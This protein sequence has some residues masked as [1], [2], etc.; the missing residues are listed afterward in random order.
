MK[1][2]THLTAIGCIVFA[3]SSFVAADSPSRPE[4][5]ITP[6]LT[7]PSAYA[8][9]VDGVERPMDTQ[10]REQTPQW[11]LWTDARN[12]QPGHSGMTFGNSKSPG[13]RHLR[14][15]FRQVIPVGSVVVRG[16][17]TLSV[18]RA[19]AAYPGDLNDDSQWIPAGRLVDAEPTRN[20][21][22]ESRVGKALRQGVGLWTLPPGVKTRAIRFTHV[23]Q[24]ADESY[25]GRLGGVMVLTQR[26][27][28]LAPLATP[29][30][31]SNQKHVA[32]IINGAKDQW[33]EWE[34][35]DGKTATESGRPVI[36]ESNPEWLMLT[37]PRAVRIDRLITLWTGFGAAEVLV[38]AGPESRHPREA[39]D[40][41]WRSVGIYR[42]LQNG[43]PAQLWPNA[44]LFPEPVETRAIRLR[45]IEPSVGRHP[46]TVERP[47]G[48]KRVWLGELFACHN[49]GDAPLKTGVVDF[50]RNL[51]ARNS[52][53]FHYG[54]Q[55]VA[56]APVPVRFHL[57]DD[58]FVTLVIEDETGKRVRNL[59]SE[60]PF[61]AGDNVVWWDAT[62]DL[63]RDIE[64]A[65]HGLYNIPARL[66]SPGRYSARGLWRKEIEPFYEFA[67]YGT[68]NPP[69][70]TPDH[71]GAW[72]AN[73]SPPSAAVFVPARTSP[74]G[75]PAVFLGCYVT[76]GPDG[77]AWVDLDGTKRGG[78]KWIG[79]H[80]TA[81]PYLGRDTGPEAPADV[82]AYVASTWET[83]KKSSI[84]ELRVTALLRSGSGL[85][86]EPVVAHRL[87]QSEAGR[88]QFEQLG[89]IA[90]YN[91]V[92]VCSFRQDDHLLWI[93]A[94]AGKVLGTTNVPSPRGVCFDAQ[95][96]LLV[97]SG[98]KLL[99]FAEARR[100]E[101]LS[102]PETVISE[103]LDDPFGLTVA[104]G[105]GVEGISFNGKPKATV[106]ASAANTDA[107]G[108]PL[109]E[110]STETIYIS[111]HGQRH[112]VKLFDAD[113]KPIRTIG[114]P[115]KPRAGDYDKLHMN[116]PAGIAVDS[117]GQ[118]W[119]T[120]HDYLPKRVS[121]WSQEGE[122]VNAFYG[123]SKYGGGGALDS[124][125]PSLFY[126]ADEA[127]GSLEFALDWE[128]GTS[129]LKRVL[130]RARTDFPMP[131]R[132]AAPERSLYHNGQRYFTNCYNTNPVAGH[133]TA[134]LFQDRDGVA[135]PAAAMGMAN[136]WD[137]LKTEPFL[138]LWPEGPDPHSKDIHGHGGR[139]QVFFAWSDL[140]TDARVQPEEVWMEQAVCGGVTVM[141]D[142]SFC[143]ARL[144]DQ[145]VR[146]TPTSF[147]TAGIPV[148]GRS[149]RVVLA[150]GVQRPGSSGGDQVL[151]DASNEAVITLGVEPFHR[152]SL[153][154]TR[155][156][157]PVWSYPSP[158]PGL[159][160]SHEA[161]SPSFPG[162]VIGSTRLMG[163]LF[164]VKG[165]EAGPLWAVNANM[166][167]FY[168][169]TRDGLFVATVF[170]D[171]RQ[172]KL[173]KMP[174]ATRG[175]PLQGISL[176]DENFWPTITSTP[177]GKVY[178]VDGSYSSLVRLEGLDTIR[179]LD[180]FSVEVTAEHLVEA[181]RWVLAR[182]AQ[183][184]AEFGQGVLNASI[185]PTS[186]IKTDGQSDD[187]SNANWVDIEKRGVR[188]NF[189]SNSQPFNVSGSLAI[190][191]DRLHAAWRTTLN[192][193]LRNS[194]EIPH[195]LF[196]TGGGLDLMLATNPAA[197]PKRRSP[198]AGDLRLLITQVDG[199]PRAL[200]YE[201]VSPGSTGEKVPFSSPW[202]TTTFDRVEDVSDQIELATDGK[203]FYE[204][205]ISLKTLGLKATDG[206]RMKGDIGILRGTGTETTARSY[207]SN[208][209]TGIT[210]DVP[211]E[212]ALT[213]HLWGTIQWKTS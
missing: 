184:Q 119:V 152:H 20:P 124:A 162:Q 151:A 65:R 136:A 4:T 42:G 68:G 208:K 94:A 35:V 62:D 108:L 211:S 71:T 90:A 138:F 133:S 193:L 180:A 8:E 212:A 157:K 18:L 101:K 178:A 63:G 40:G 127:R 175:M 61:P 199:K 188:A 13:A 11:V 45:M 117:K 54:V 198:V 44:M 145:A 10:R 110:D 26:L 47:A 57:P 28:N 115:G 153:S 183:R 139:N 189:N 21:I 163:G 73:H 144:N 84:T 111:D 12:G 128:K 174:V 46:H 58:G 5:P 52:G 172:G 206:L 190:S 197:D 113:G 185:H 176:H 75:E 24:P 130:Y 213:P 112:Q 36:S 51:N 135:Q 123:P 205:S 132:A 25:A 91:G 129:E 22:L 72:L 56:H 60:T 150:D 14:I 96:R 186:R 78:L 77:F 81:A 38:Y 141:E 168:L 114:R 100:P 34:N 165:C 43:Y 87:E 182:E 88:H 161:A 203:G 37:W 59:V 76:E 147:T 83:D 9:W 104:S 7:N 156:G 137:V 187:W 118:I 103:G 64:A 210:A 69:W 122:L 17:G 93:D 201:P 67:V 41:D 171:V 160:A 29:A 74:T 27:T 207:W 158:W 195:A 126:Y 170:E 55:S 16:G 143:I 148:Y 50:A 1:S 80:W 66:V 70:S 202:R 121:V 125:D 106:R 95:G 79:G 131:F 177:E 204:F 169:F 120:E 30:A 134:F 82:A 32:K 159:H 53:E 86:P 166:G 33:G 192:D 155:D 19:D 196:K 107:S 181:Q 209:A 154:G 48:G 2:P 85:K 98:T 15:G 149:N 194:G 6:E 99:R 167:N 31:G 105:V 116:H 102:R 146:F 97:L 39:E 23:A 3:A 89:G 109:N 191:G 49:L 179:R 164:E 200:L 92:I 142:L 173:W 140:N